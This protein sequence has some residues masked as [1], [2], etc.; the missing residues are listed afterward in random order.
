MTSDAGK[1]RRERIDSRIAVIQGPVS[2][3]YLFHWLVDGAWRVLP[4]TFCVVGAAWLVFAWSY[5]GTVAGSPRRRRI[6]RYVAITGALLL[7]APGLGSVGGAP[8]WPSTDVT[9]CLAVVHV[10]LA[11]VIAAISRPI[12]F[13]SGPRFGAAAPAASTADSGGDVPAAATTAART[14]RLSRML[15]MALAVA[16]FGSLPAFLFLSLITDAIAGEDY[17]SELTAAVDAETG[18]PELESVISW[19]GAGPAD[20]SASRLRNRL[21]A[22]MVPDRLGP[23]PRAEIETSLL[24]R[25]SAYDPAAWPALQQDLIHLSRS[26]PSVALY[27]ADDPTRFNSLPRLREFFAGAELAFAGATTIRPGD[28]PVAI[29]TVT[30]NWISG[31]LPTFTRADQALPIRLPPPASDDRPIHIADLPNGLLGAAT[32]V[33]VNLRVP[34]SPPWPGPT[35][36]LFIIDP[37]VWALICVVAE[38]E[39]PSAAPWSRMVFGDGLP[40][41]QSRDALWPYPR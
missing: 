38:Y 8:T 40:A 32:T 9:L 25:Y 36:M 13:D 27:V 22:R 3:A 30:L 31:G 5:I 39:Y 20:M 2:L 10:A 4:V 35:G 24:G 33:D 1:R 19:T 34:G 37:Q 16:L 6:A 7:V 23:F 15:T 26:R 12:P 21:P 17:A 18:A 11:F 14:T 41:D 28:P 29:G